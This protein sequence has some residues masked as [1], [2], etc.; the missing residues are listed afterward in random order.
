VSDKKA[1]NNPASHKASQDEAKASNFKVLNKEEKENSV[2]ELTIEIERDFL[3]TYND[4]SIEELGKDVEVDGFRK[5]KAPKEKVVEK[6]GE[7]KVFEKNLFKAINTLVPVVLAGQKLNVITMPNINVTKIALG[8]NPE[9]KIVATLMPEIELADYKKIAQE[10]PAE[11]AEEA[12]DKEVDEYIEYLRK[13]K[14]QVATS[15]EN[16]DKEPKLPDFNDEFVKT[17]GDFKDVNDFK[18]KLKEN[19]SKDKKIHT[20]QKRRVTIIEKILKDSKIDMPQ[21][22]IDEELNR[23]LYEFKAKVEGFKMEFEDYLKELKKSEEDLKKEWRADAE[24]RAKMNLVLPK[25]AMEEDIK[26]D[27]KEIEKEIKHI[28]EHHKD[29]NEAQA[30]VYVANVLTNEGVFKFL[31]KL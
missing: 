22:L 6:V 12:T 13:N 7:M 28:K 11:K 19:M 23:M 24:K 30:K 2:I 5:G 18:V 8:T 29:V 25:I 1:N 15:P 16:K 27:E 21:I 14:A 3:E 17:L 31:E 26:L 10:S 4:A 9:I 20:E